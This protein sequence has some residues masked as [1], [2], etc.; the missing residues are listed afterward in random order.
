[1]SATAVNL[2]VNRGFR[3]W[4][5]TLGKK[6]VMAVTG[7][8]LFGF[9]V[10]HL[11]GNL[12]IFLPPEKINHYAE[13]LH[14]APALLW[15][16][17]ITL[18]ASVTLHIWASLQLWK[19]QLDARP[20]KYFRKENLTSSYASRTMML[21][22]P[23]I[24]AFVI[25]H[26]LQFTF[27]AVAVPGYDVHDVYHN[28]VAGF[29]IWWVSAFYIVAM[30]LLCFHLYHGLWSMFQSLGFSHPKYTPWLKRFAAV[31]AYIILLG[32]IS[33]PVA[34]LAGFVGAK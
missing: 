27:G 13:L 14:S 3:F 2:S 10:G 8:I 23:I 9:L 34:I 5:T 11:L 12:Q 21:S 19:L 28:V 18:L 24:A 4:Q 29:S 16:A 20:V 22:G 33:I 32:N 7:F 17:R 30:I 1:M 26:L 25:F 6:A 15:G 31:F